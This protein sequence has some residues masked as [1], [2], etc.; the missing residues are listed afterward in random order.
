MPGSAARKKKPAST[1]A[2]ASSPPSTIGRNPLDALISE[3]AV[4]HVARRRAKPALVPAPEM[5]PTHGA[6]PGV[7]LA[8]TVPKALAEQVQAILAVRTDLSFDQLMSTAL[9]TVLAEVRPGHGPAR[10]RRG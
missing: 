6:G 10:S 5:V 2:A 9:S 1:R 8:I 3:S 4:L 7:K